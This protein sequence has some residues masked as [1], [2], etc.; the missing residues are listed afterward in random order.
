MQIGTQQ[1]GAVLA[2][3]SI[4]E[5]LYAVKE[6]SIY[7][8]RLAEEI[9]PQRTNPT[10]P[11]S[12]QKLFSYG[13]DSPLVGRTLLT[14]SELLDRSYLGQTF[15]QESGLAFAFE[16]LKCLIAMD[17]IKSQVQASI[18]IAKVGE[19]TRKPNGS[20]TIP[21]VPDLRAR[22][23]AFI[24]QAQRS[25]SE[26]LNVVKLFFG[27]DSGRRWFES[28]TELVEHR[29]GEEDGFAD[30]MRHVLPFLQMVRTARNCVEHPKAVEYV[31]VTDFALQADG[32]VYLPT[33]EVVH[34][35]HPL[36]VTPVLDFMNL[37]SDHASQVF[38]VML[39][40]LCEKNLR[41]LPM[42]EMH[43]VELPEEQRRYKYVR[44]AYRGRI[45]TVEDNAATDD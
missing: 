1:D 13:S 37:V 38:E 41:Q 3:L 45:L 30:F 29:Y 16:A 27:I 31:T 15:D 26:L 40:H 25:L 24:Q 39:A 8:V 18:E 7:T 21:S 10:I 34:Q 9:D 17:E 2:M 32:K 12:Q 23:V 6:K 35:K 14:A 36:H 11:N 43:L 28:L 19:L 4:R 22:C 33:I 5:T 42:A 20:I 44:Y